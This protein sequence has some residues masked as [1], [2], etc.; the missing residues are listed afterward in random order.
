MFLLYSTIHPLS[1]AV[2]T[3]YDSLIN[4]L[5]IYRIATYKGH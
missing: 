4:V 3:V 2:I 1:T 5:I